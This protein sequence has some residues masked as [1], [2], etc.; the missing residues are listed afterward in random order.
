MKGIKKDKN[1]VSGSVK[2]AS[3]VHE[4]LVNHCKE[5]GTLISYFATE[6]VKEK[7]EKSKPKH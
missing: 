6:A 7:L 3:E 1:N 4:K 2:I 5:S